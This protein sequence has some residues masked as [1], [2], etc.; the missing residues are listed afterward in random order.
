M[1]NVVAVHPEHPEPDI[2]RRAAEVLR[3]GGLVA[4][5]T[6]T[7]YGLGADA[8][9]PRA[10]ARIFEVKGRPAH[11]PL[12]VH[13]ASAEA[14]PQVAAALPPRAL[15]LARRF[16]PGPL[17][18]VLPKAPHVPDIVTAGLPTVAVRVPAHPVAL[19]LIRAAGCPVAAPSAN[20]FGHAS[21]TRAEHVVADLGD[22]VDLILD[23]GPTPIGVE[24][25]VLDLTQDSPVILRPG[26]VPREALEA[27]LGPVRLRERPAPTQ[28]AAPS[29]GML[30]RHYAP[31][32]SALWLFRGPRDQALT[33]LLATLRDL[34]GRGKRV[35]LLLPEEDVRAL[36]SRLSPHVKVEALGPESTPEALARRLFE[37]LRRL[38]GR[39][40]VILARDVTERGLGLAVRDRLRRAA[41]R[42]FPEA[43]TERR[44]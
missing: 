38:E 26:G 42:I 23:A 33:W 29:P 31:E 22:A 21:P 25:T 44:E 13:L 4:F 8:L 28:Q 5:P 14:L 7:V 18:L 12:I 6:E 9:N 20:R 36:A 24:S 34:Q 37:G 19:A 32:K 3:R 35:G 10:V 41:D 2:I 16:M 17:T 43:S 39:V 15:V 11:D 30:S 40:D 27:V 1:T